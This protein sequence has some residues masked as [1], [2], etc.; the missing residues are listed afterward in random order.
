MPAT[1]WL[2]LGQRLEAAFA[3]FALASLSDA[4]DGWLA[5]TFNQRSRFGAALDPVADKALMISVFVMLAVIGALPAWLAILVVLRDVVILS[6]L[7]VLWW[8]G[9]RPVIRPIWLSKAN[10]GA[11]MMLAALAL[12]WAAFQPGGNAPL[13]ILSWLVAATTVASGVA[14]IAGGAR[15]LVRSP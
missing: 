14:Y 3:V 6:G 12:F 13:L 8:R 15:L 9:R 5:R 4:V 1:V 11:Q 10:T 2:M 7:A